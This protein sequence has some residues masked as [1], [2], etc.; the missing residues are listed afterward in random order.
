LAEANAL[1][2]ETTARIGE[3]RSH[4]DTP[5]DVLDALLKH[6]ER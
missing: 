3:L 5:F 2:A 4:L 6:V 1:I